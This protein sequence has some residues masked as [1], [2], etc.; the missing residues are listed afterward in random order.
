MFKLRVVATLTRHDPG[1][2]NISVCA[3]PE[4][5]RVATAMRVDDRR[6]VLLRAGAVVEEVGDGFVTHETQYVGDPFPAQASRAAKAEPIPPQ[7]NRAF[8]G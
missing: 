4:A 5:P 7:S 6:R 1:R 3:T 8:L 2:M